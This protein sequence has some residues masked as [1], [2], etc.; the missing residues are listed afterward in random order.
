[1]VD[2]RCCGPGTGLR[3]ASCVGASRGGGCLRRFGGRL[4][5]VCWCAEILYSTRA[6]GRSD[7]LM[8]LAVR[9]MPSSR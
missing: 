2:T 3:Q 6:R 9:W 1:M 5:R 8:G 4:R 7:G